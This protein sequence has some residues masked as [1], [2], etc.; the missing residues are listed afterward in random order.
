MK[1]GRGGKIHAQAFSNKQNG[2]SVSSSFSL[3]VWNAVLC[4]KL[5]LSS[6]LLLKLLKSGQTTN[7]IPSLIEPKTLQMY[8]WKTLSMSAVPPLLTPHQR[9]LP[10]CVVTCHSQ[11]RTSVGPQT[12]LCT[13][14]KQRATHGSHSGDGKA[15][16]D[17]V[18]NTVLFLKIN[19]ISNKS[20]Y[21]NY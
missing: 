6:S 13:L 21:M 8:V 10:T 3:A 9:L 11:S 14:C 15:F 4:P 17:V 20:S 19:K 5:F 12:M 2:K 18:E 1:I 16:L 7:Q